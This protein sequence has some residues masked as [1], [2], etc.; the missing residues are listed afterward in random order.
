MATMVATAGVRRLMRAGSWVGLLFLYLPRVVILIYAF[1]PTV[2]QSW[3]PSGFTTRWFSVAFH[4]REIRTSLWLSVKA[5]LGATA[6]ALVL[7]SLAA[8]AVHR[9]RFFGR[10][11]VSFLLVLPIALP[12]I[13]TGLALNSAIDAAGLSF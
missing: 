11:T 5:G 9:F 13:V 3:P 2:A 1:N 12:G 6:L 7:G 8:F 4:N 10:E